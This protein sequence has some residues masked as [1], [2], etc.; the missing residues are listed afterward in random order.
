MMI[1]TTT[2]LIEK[3]LIDKTTLVA[4]AHGGRRRAGRRGPKYLGSALIRTVHYSC[5]S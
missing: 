2:W 3:W 5:D 4:A 1:A